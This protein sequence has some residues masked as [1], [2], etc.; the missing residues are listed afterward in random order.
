[1]PG[2]VGVITKLPEDE[3]LAKLGSMIRLVH[4]EP[5]YSTGQWHDTESGVY[6]GWALRE[7]H[8]PVRSAATGD[9]TIILSGEH[10][11]GSVPPE[12]DEI[13]R[14]L[15]GFFHGVQVDRLTGTATLFNDRYGLHR[16][17]CHQDRDGFYFSTEAKAILAICPE[18]RK[19]DERSLGEYV[20]LG[21]VLCNRSL[22]RG[23]VVLPPG[24]AWR[25]ENASLVNRGRYFDPAEWE[26]QQPLDGEA[27]YQEVRAAV[28]NAIPAYLRAE[29]T[30]AIALTGGL[31]TRVVMAWSKAAPGDL[32]CYTYGGDTRDSCD[33]MIGRLVAELCGQR[34]Q[35]LR[36]GED[37]LS[38]F[39]RYAARTVYLS[40]GCADV[41]H[42]TDL[43]LSEQARQIAPVKVVGTWGS[44]ILRRLVTFKPAPCEPGL[45]DADLES[46]ARL[47]ARTYQQELSVHPVTFSAFKQTP[48]AQFGVEAIEQTQVRV[49]APFLDIHFVKAA[50]RAPAH[51]RADVRSRLVAEGRAPIAS[52]PTD[53]GVTGNGNGLRGFARRCWQEATFKAEYLSDLG[54]PHW[55]ARADRLFAPAR[56]GERFLG[57]HKFC[58]F[59][60]WYRT[61]LKDYMLRVL[62]DP[63]TH[64]RSYLV[65]SGI[66]RIARDHASGKANHTATIHRLLSLELIER[67]L[68]RESRA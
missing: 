48:W 17:Y 33:V 19:L 25:F 37:F 49:R 42:A 51:D 60:L 54:M 61:R 52:I 1:M 23:I 43:Y 15:N 28:E 24:S 27:Y 14:H 11:G 10:I 59:R 39:E 26:S 66:E 44:E 57:R 31:D 18:T 36:V 7:A 53:R 38:N 40:D 3:A 22:F 21:C 63:Q 2:L 67:H 50:Y 34:H 9:R 20:A 30:L 64:S 65:R 46:Q 58:H 16:L 12:R 45:Y 6:V 68:V 56:L 29:D 5:F 62:L 47:A 32:P 8:R 4:H 41:S 13:W 35:T 55:F